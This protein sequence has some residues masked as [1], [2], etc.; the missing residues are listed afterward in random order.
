MVEALLGAFL[1]PVTYGEGPVTARLP[2]PVQ[3]VLIYM[4]QL[5]ENEAHRPVTLDDLARVSGVSGKHLCRL[6]QSSLHHPPLATLRLLKLQFGLVLL[7][8]SHLAIKEIA[9]RCGFDNPLYF[10]RC[11]TQVYRMSPTEAR[12][13][14]EARKAPPVGP[15][16]A[17]LMPRLFW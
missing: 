10:S 8:R 11:F 4:R 2:K 14:M 13:R 1:D 9:D 6:F 7:A 16:P 3:D 17:D 12:Q 5:L 15:L